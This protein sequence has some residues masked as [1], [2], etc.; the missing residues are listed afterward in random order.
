MIYQTRHITRYTYSAPIRESIMEVRMQPR[1]DGNQRCTEFSLTVRPQA[2]PAC[3]LDHQGNVVHHF[4]IPG[5]HDQ[6]FLLAEA[7]VEVEPLPPLP[8]ALPPEAWNELDA[9]AAGGDFWDTLQPSL[10]ARP[11][12]LLE[13]LARELRV[14]RAGDPLST[15]L[16]VNRALYAAFSYEPQSTTV[17][18]AIDE[19]IAERRGVCQDFSHIM[20][21]LVRGLGIPCRYVSGYLFHQRKDQRHDRSEEDASHAWV[22]AFLPGLGWRGFDPTNNLIAGDRHIR[23]AEGRDYA[24][25][26]PTR[27][28]FRGRA[29]SQ[30]GVSVRVSPTYLPLD[31]EEKV[32]MT[33]VAAAPPPPKRIDQQQQQ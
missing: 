12:R 21:A 7:T 26:P 24:D 11:T 13:D 29:S 30:L 8:E 18:S 22:E 9:A 17:D 31:A 23:V 2:R 20:I 14:D 32:L 16:H 4:D 1:S 10:F 27:G 15:L 33:T 3:Y 19:A 6:L 5:Q 25:V 28:V